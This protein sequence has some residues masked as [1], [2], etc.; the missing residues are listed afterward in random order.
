MKSDFSYSPGL[1]YNT[2]PWPKLTET[3][4]V[5]L[6]GLAQAIL[7]ARDAHPG[8]ILADLY[9][10]DVMPADLRRAHRALD[11]A[12]DRLYR[13][14][15]FDSDRER[16]EHLFTLYEKMTAGLLAAPSKLK[17]RKKADA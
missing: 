16:V 4:K 9:D 17:R 1:V 2:F 5:R 13:K 3:D 12:V 6:A 15:P 10:P 11:Q 7:D 14:A 8:T